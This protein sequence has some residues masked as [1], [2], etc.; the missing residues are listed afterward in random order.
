L[1]FSFHFNLQGAKMKNHPNAA[2][3]KE[4]VAAAS[5]DPVSISAYA[6]RHALEVKSLYYWRQKIRE[7]NAVPKAANSSVSPFVAV[8]VPE[9]I[10]EQRAANCTLVLAQDIRLEMTAPPTPEWLA[11]F[12]RAMQ[13]IC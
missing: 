2:F 8:R 6:K 12:I 10:N 13:G 7:F 9:K 1:A 4:H 5:Q 3:W 11:N